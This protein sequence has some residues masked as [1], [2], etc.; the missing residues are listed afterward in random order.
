MRKTYRG[1]YRNTVEDEGAYWCLLAH[2][3][4]PDVSE[5]RYGIAQYPFVPGY[6]VVDY[7][8]DHEYER[9]ISN[10]KTL[11]EAGAILRL[12]ATDPSAVTRDG[13]YE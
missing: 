11:A 6:N 4:D 8:E 1:L 13:V 2:W 10:H 12:L 3:T 7:G 5:W 9:V